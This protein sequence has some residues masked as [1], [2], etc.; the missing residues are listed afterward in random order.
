MTTI[1]RATFTMAM[2]EAVA[3]KGEDYRYQPADSEDKCLYVQGGEPAC[4]IGYALHRCGVQIAELARL[5]RA[6]YTATSALRFYASDEIIAEAARVAQRCQD[7]G[8]TW[9]QALEAY[10]TELGEFVTEATSGDYDHL[11]QTC[12]EWVECG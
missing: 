12:M 2:R 8:K 5:D 3:E 10:E 7:S 6:C 11:I 4:I 1:D 9:G